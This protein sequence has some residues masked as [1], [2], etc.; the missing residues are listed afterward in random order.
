MHDR[1]LYVTDDALRPCSTSSWSP[2]HGHHVAEALPAGAS[3]GVHRG[4][5]RRR[6][7]SVARAEATRRSQ[8][9]VRTEVPSGLTPR[10]PTAAGTASRTHIA[11]VL[12]IPGRQPA[13]L[14]RQRHWRIRHAS[15][16]YQQ[17]SLH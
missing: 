10:T 11:A 17:S 5:R 3:R 8:G 12:R 16:V 15:A 2:E 4:V 6:A 13:G 9:R 1:F 7:A 14:E